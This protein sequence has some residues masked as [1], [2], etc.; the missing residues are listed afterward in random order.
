MK[1]HTARSL[2]HCPKTWGVST[3]AVLGRR[4]IPIWSKNW[5]TSCTLTV[6]WGHRPRGSGDKL[7][8]WRFSWVALAATEDTL[9]A[10]RIMRCS[11]DSRCERK[12]NEKK[13]RGGKGGS[14]QVYHFF[15]FHKGRSADWWCAWKE[16]CQLT[17]FFFSL[18]EENF[19]PFCE[20]FLESS[21]TLYP[22]TWRRDLLSLIIWLGNNGVRIRDFLFLCWGGCIYLVNK[23]LMKGVSDVDIPMKK[24][25]VK[26]LLE[27][28]V[29]KQLHP[30][31]THE[32]LFWHDWGMALWGGGKWYTPHLRI[33]VQE[34]EGLQ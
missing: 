6:L 5:D 9:L 27:Q 22:R 11:V 13:E 15:C 14:L 7:L 24:E 32:N 20:A 31:V 23:Q 25:R 10:C 26:T 34:D 17:Y 2:K 4:L 29:A 21:L 3:W 1:I 12:G 33:F 16:E 28:K 19:Q 8:L 18:E 30:G